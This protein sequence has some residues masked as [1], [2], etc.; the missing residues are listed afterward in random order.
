[1]KLLIEQQYEFDVS[2]KDNVCEYYQFYTYSNYYRQLYFLLQNHKTAHD[3]A[4]DNGFS[5]IAELVI[6]EADNI[7]GSNVETDEPNACENM[8]MDECQ[9]KTTDGG[10]KPTKA[11]KDYVPLLRRR[12]KLVCLHA[13]NLY[14][15]MHAACTFV[16]IQLV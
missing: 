7:S 6:E 16:H 2:L 9:L 10:I 14:I 5:E 3:V 8:G 15:C 1:M 13:Y 4:L 12:S 11:R